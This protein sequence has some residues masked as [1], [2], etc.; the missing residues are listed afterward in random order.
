MIRCQ[1]D[2]I[3]VGVTKDVARRFEEHS[4]QGGRC[5]KYLRGRAP[6]QLIS[7]FQLP[8]KKSAHQLEYRL[9]RKPKSLKEALAAGEVALQA[10]L[11]A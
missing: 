2:S 5:A 7:V 8:D 3:Y 11:S 6:L 9:K 1:D 10:V 4:E